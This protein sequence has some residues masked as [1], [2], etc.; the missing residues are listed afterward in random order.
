M[1]S[2]STR[3][4]RGQCATPNQQPRVKGLTVRRDE[5]SVYSVATER[6]CEGEDWAGWASG[7]DPR[8]PLYRRAYCD[9]TS[10]SL[11]SRA[12]IHPFPHLVLPQPSSWL[13]SHDGAV[14]EGSYWQRPS[15]GCVTIWEHVFPWMS[16]H[17]HRNV[18][19]SM[20]THTGNDVGQFSAPIL[21][22]A[23]NRC[24]T[25][26]TESSSISIAR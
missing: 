2:G 10:Y 6:W 14:L 23:Q 17:H 19:N 3:A 25:Q 5:D 8:P 13:E 15:D 18:H 21:H 7:A 16:Y 4:I 9:G 11:P 20:G 12:A 24:V 26:S 22:I 1:G